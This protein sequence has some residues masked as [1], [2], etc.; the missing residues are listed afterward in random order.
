MNKRI[1]LLFVIVVSLASSAH[2]GSNPV[3]WII[4]NWAQNDVWGSSRLGETCTFYE[5]ERGYSIV[6]CGPPTAENISTWIVEEQYEIREVNRFCS[7]D[8]NAG[9]TVPGTRDGC[10]NG[11]APSNIRSHPLKGP[12]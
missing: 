5:N 12:E 6:G 10:V 9:K 4:P 8:A 1:I 11:A 7:I 3:E 2:A